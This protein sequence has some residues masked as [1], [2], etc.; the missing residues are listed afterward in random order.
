LSLVVD[1]ACLDAMQ[2][3]KTGLVRWT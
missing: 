3:R 2:L 1:V